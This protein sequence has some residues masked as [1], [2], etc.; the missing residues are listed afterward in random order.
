MKL[1]EVEVRLARGATLRVLSLP[2]STRARFSTNFF[3]ET[4][5]IITD[6]EGARV[7]AEL[8]WALSYH[9]T[10]STVVLLH[11]EHLVPSHDDVSGRRDDA[12]PSPA[13]T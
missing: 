6:R 10:P 12:P 2:P 13:R 4:W 8:L 7:L 5:H 3:H 9:R 1:H 11:G